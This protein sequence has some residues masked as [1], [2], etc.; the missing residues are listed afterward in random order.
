[1]PDPAPPPWPP[2][3][4]GVTLLHA[5][6]RV[7]VEV[8][9]LTRLLAAQPE[10]VA[11]RVDVEAATTAVAVRIGSLGS[12]LDQLRLSLLD[13]LE[14]TTAR[15]DQPP[16][17]PDLHA[18]L[19]DLAAGRPVDDELRRALSELRT[20]ID[21]AITDA[22]SR[23][24]RIETGVRDL[25]QAG[26]ASQRAVEAALA[27]A[28]DR[29][30]VLAAL[31][32]Q[33]RLSL[34]AG[35]DRAIDHVDGPRWLP[36]LQRAVRQDPRLDELVAVVTS[37]ADG[38]R[39]SAAVAGALETVDERLAA[40]EA[41]A[42][43]VAQR[44]GAV[45]AKLEPF[46][47]R[48][49]AMS[50]QLD[51]LTPLARAG[52]GAGSLL[53]QLNRLG[54]GLEEVVRHI[55]SRPAGAGD[56]DG[57]GDDSDARLDAVVEVLAGIARRQDETTAAIQA[58]LHHLRDSRGVPS[59]P[60]RQDRGERA[61]GSRLN[62]IEAALRRRDDQPAGGRPE[63][64]APSD[65]GARALRAALDRLDQQ[66]QVMAKQ[67]ERVSQHVAGHQGTR[68]AAP[69]TE[70]AVAET[71]QLE[72]AGTLGE[73]LAELSRRHDELA[74]A[75]DRRLSAIEAGLGADTTGTRPAPGPARTGPSAAPQAAAQRLAELRAERARIQ[76]Q[77]RDERLL[78]AQARGEDLADVPDQG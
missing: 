18:A 14:R 37:V 49:Q 10:D 2:G 5:V 29:V 58:V 45:A 19:G 63:A 41:S 65:D 30:E 42:E 57:D 62:R 23:A 72:R 74:D 22:G 43:R 27:G 56:G 8:A 21:A 77:L 66:E 48:L 67:L 44:A 36:E 70:P 25:T 50:V 7:G 33:L 34:L 12:T 38:V 13:A 11:A 76:A 54:G 35:L 3:V 47:R 53:G 15:L 61:L 24:A 59:P 51:R 46:D 26:P 60:D 1:M 73:V 9:A 6:D 17:L 40:V 39:A 20:T 55:S 69:A 68:G 31:V 71:D 64:D 75:I 52:D 78:A 4:D 32:E 28:G 16:W